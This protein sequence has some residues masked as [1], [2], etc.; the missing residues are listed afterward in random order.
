MYVETVPCHGREI[1]LESGAFST[2]DTPAATG[3]PNSHANRLPENI[4]AVHLSG[5]LQARK[6]HSVGSLPRKRPLYHRDIRCSRVPRDGN[7]Q[8]ACFYKYL[9]LP[10]LR[11]T[12]ITL[13]VTYC[14]A[15]SVPRK[16]RTRNSASRKQLITSSPLPPYPPACPV[17]TCPPHHPCRPAHSPAPP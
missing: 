3:I 12:V 7:L 17:L 11:C 4:K 2:P 15:K 8:V 1:A 16:H 13:S 14:H 10:T 9:P 6:L 5:P